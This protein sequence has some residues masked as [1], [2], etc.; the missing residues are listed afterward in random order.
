MR[1]TTLAADVPTRGTAMANFPNPDGNQTFVGTTDA[2]TYYLAFDGEVIVWH[3]EIVEQ[4]SASGVVD[5]LQVDQPLQNS[6][7]AMYGLFDGVAGYGLLIY[8]KSLGTS[9][10]LRDQLTD[11]FSPK[12]ELLRFGS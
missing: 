2:D 9:M 1:S 11:V 3:D 8:I 12:V 6:D 5:V 7:L 4:A 10:L